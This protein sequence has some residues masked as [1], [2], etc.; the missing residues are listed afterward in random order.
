M[1]PRIVYDSGL[2]GRPSFNYTQVVAG[3][4]LGGLGAN[5]WLPATT[6]TIGRGF[7][8]QLWVLQCG[9]TSAVS[10]GPSPCPHRLTGRGWSAE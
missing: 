6:L 10:A 4:G 8:C 7:H 2:C 3:L 1:N 9:L 5:G